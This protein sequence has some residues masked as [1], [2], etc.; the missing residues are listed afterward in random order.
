[1]VIYK[2]FV[3]GA[4]RK[5]NMAARA[6]NVF[7][8]V[9]ILKIFLLETT[10]P[11]ELWLCRN[12]KILYMTIQWTF[13]PS[14]IQ[15]CFVV[16]EKRW[17]CEIPIGSYVKLSRVMEAILNFRSPKT[18]ILYI[19]VTLQEWSLGGSVLNLWIV[20]RSEIQD[21]TMTRLSLT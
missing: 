7:W 16:S 1:M 14:L 10:K 3:F 2:I 19:I 21:G 8:L 18:Q 20:C 4:D 12:D 9:E 11:I 17:K 13:L 15:I 5:C 6:H